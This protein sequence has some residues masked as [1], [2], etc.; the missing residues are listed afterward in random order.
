MVIHIDSSNLTLNSSNASSDDNTPRSAP[1][2]MAE[3]RSSTFSITHDI[4]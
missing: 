1:T 4:L 2:A 3:A